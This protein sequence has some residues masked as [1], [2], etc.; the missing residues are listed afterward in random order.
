METAP[1]LI[2]LTEENWKHAARNIPAAFR[3]VEGISPEKLRPIKD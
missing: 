1:Y 2:I 3:D